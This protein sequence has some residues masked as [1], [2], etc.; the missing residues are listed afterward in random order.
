VKKLPTEVGKEK[1]MSKKTK[2]PEVISEA[3]SDSEA[4]DRPR[5]TI[6]R[7]VFVA[8]KPQVGAWAD[9]I[10][11]RILKLDAWAVRLGAALGLASDPYDLA[12][13][14][15][16]VGKEDSTEDDLQRY[17]PA[18]G[19][20]LDLAKPSQM[21]GAT[22][23]SSNGADLLF[24]FGVALTKSMTPLEQVTLEQREGKWGLYYHRGPAPF[25][26]AA[27][28]TVKPSSV[29]LKDAPLAVRERFLRHAEAFFRRYV[30]GAGT[31]LARMKESVEGGDAA[32]EMLESLSLK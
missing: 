32:L 24:A 4:T 20:A 18:L 29:P 28:T 17:N 30:E 11:E 13:L 26:S 27:A 12:P 6:R 5:L 9:Q 10:N 15:P 16:A 14:Y 3:N 25:G 21:A 23:P 2:V 7:D 22:T 31:R 1:Q 19:T 8:P